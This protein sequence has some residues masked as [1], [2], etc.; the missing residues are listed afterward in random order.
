MYLWRKNGRS[1]NHCAF[2]VCVKGVA[3][4]QNR[5]YQK[6]VPK[7]VLGRSTNGCVQFKIRRRLGTL[8]L[9]CSNSR[10]TMGLSQLESVAASIDLLERSQELLFEASLLAKSDQIVDV[11]A[12]S[13]HNLL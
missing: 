3:K 4:N 12:E 2:C 10:D 5:V 7:D 1:K 8:S 13:L 11:V 9:S 6:L